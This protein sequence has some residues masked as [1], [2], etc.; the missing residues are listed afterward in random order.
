M[1]L[2]PLNAYEVQKDRK[3]VF[4]EDERMME[5]G[6]FR[7][8][9]ENK[10]TIADIEKLLMEELRKRYMESQ[11]EEDAYYD[12]IFQPKV[13]ENYAMVDDRSLFKEEV[14]TL[15]SAKDED[16]IYELYDQGRL[17]IT[18]AEFKYY[19]SEEIFHWVFEE[20]WMLQNDLDPEE[21]FKRNYGEYFYNQ[22]RELS[23]QVQERFSVLYSQTRKYE[24]IFV[25]DV[26]SQEDE[27]KYFADILY[28]YQ[29]SQIDLNYLT[30]RLMEQLQYV[31]K[32]YKFQHDSI[33][34]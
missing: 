33:D 10:A 19:E 24:D 2:F 31:K 32:G 5:G 16:E 3:G 14:Q 1:M 30:T 22:P 9:H 8:M 12:D 25:F 11:G 18:K 13:Y 15:T 21:F 23:Q 6:V 4:D 20:A 17:G 34:L 26:Y 29:N 28:V 7:R 27:Y